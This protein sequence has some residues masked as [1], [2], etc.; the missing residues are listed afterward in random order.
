MLALE[1]QLIE[2]ISWRLFTQSDIQENK[3]FIYHAD[4]GTVM[5]ISEE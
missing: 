2:A 1:Q 4:N 5:V 3:E